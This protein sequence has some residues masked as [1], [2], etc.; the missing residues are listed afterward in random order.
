[1]VKKI[2]RLFWRPAYGAFAQ[3]GAPR[4]RDRVIEFVMAGCIIGVLQALY[5][6]NNAVMPG[7]ARMT[8]NTFWNNDPEHIAS[9]EALAIEGRWDYTN[10]G[11]AVSLVDMHN[12]TVAGL[13]SFTAEYPLVVV[14]WQCKLATVPE[15]ENALK[16]LPPKKAEA[17]KGLTPVELPAEYGFKVCRRGDGSAR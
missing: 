17:Y 9:L 12:G 8:G 4:S 1:M 10:G 6:V 11:A 7:K 15:I 13:K 2:A 3:D 5:L 14:N 16:S